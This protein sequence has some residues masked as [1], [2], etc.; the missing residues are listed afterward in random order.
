M[1]VSCRGGNKSLGRKKGKGVK[2][3]G[4]IYI[5]KIIFVQFAF[6]AKHFCS[7]LVDYLMA[8]D[9]IYR[10]SLFCFGEFLKHID[11]VVQNFDF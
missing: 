1:C 3:S 8:M 4:D 5:S 10:I 7:F 2:S 9:T 11:Q 6:Y